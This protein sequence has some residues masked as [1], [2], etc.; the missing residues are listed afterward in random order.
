MSMSAVGRFVRP[1]RTLLR[2][3]LLTLVAVAAIVVG[4]LA[5]HSLNLDNTQHG[6]GSAAQMA[7]PAHHETGTAPLGEH[8]SSSDCAGVCGP[9][10][11][12]TVMAC[13][14]VL[15]VTMIVLG[16]RLAVSRW[17]ELRRWAAALVAWAVALAP[18][19]PPSLH[20]LSISR[21]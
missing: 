9:G 17:H 19:T 15:L 3:V 13:V 18:P 7:A 21:T 4:L 14:L 6:A 16:A 5:M 11:S 1:Q 20:V 10:H 8:G 12:M 2:E